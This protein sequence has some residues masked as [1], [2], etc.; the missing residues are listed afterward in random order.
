M[1]LG[2]AA[3]SSARKVSAPRSRSSMLSKLPGSAAAGSDEAMSNGP[4]SFFT[5]RIRKWPLE[6]LIRYTQLF[7]RAQLSS[8]LPSM[9]SRTLFSSVSLRFLSMNAWILRWTSSPS[10][11][12][13]TRDFGTL[14]SITGQSLKSNFLFFR[15]SSSEMPQ[16]TSFGKSRNIFSLFVP[17]TTID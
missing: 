15:L 13:C 2:I 3:L 10:T 16:R 8:T 7:T 17:W 4:D 14:W 1:S 12:I 5:F 9:K 6:S 11:V